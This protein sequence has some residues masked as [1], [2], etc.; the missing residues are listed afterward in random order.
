MITSC[1]FAD[2]LRPG[3]TVHRIFWS[4]NPGQK[5]DQTP[6]QKP[7]QNMIPTMSKK[8]QNLDPK[9]NP[10]MGQDGEAGAWAQPSGMCL[11]SS[12]SQDAPKM[13]QDGLK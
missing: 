10:K 7:D 6:T 11:G 12:W 4:K 13:A 5:S 8:V 3:R 2:V 1:C 9:M